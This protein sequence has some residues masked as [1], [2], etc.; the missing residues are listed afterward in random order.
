M[1]PRL[2][3]SL[4]AL[5]ALVAGVGP[6]VA[7]TADGPATQQATPTSTDPVVENTTFYLQLRENGD[8]RWTITD[9]YALE[10]ENDT[11]AF[12]ELAADFRNGDADTGW[13]RAFRGASDAASEATD[14][15]MNVSTVNRSAIVGERKGTLVLTFTW[16]NFAT[17]EGETLVVEDAFNT[18]DGT[19]LKTLA[20]DQRLVIAPPPGY[21]VQSAPAPVQN[22]RLEFAG[23]REFEPGD[24]SVVYTGDT[25]QTPTDTV[26]ETP[27]PDGENVSLWIGGALLIAGLLAVVGYVVTSDDPQQSG[28][29]TAAETPDDAGS[30]QPSTAPDD[31]DTDEIDPELLSDEERVERLLEQNGGR[32]KQARIVQE[33]GWSNAK[34]SQLLSSM[35][36]EDRIDK[37]RIGRENLISFPDEE[38]GDFDDE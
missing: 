23:P 24:V 10:D 1:P 14:R 6:V 9:T 3:A 32:M 7:A 31:G 12:E 4:L 11:E 25:G 5:L 13:L 29:A 15:E 17:A 26:T 28:G 18:S 2:A 21:G 38:I 36:E 27:D 19:W 35:D 20:A 16:T 33:T 30:D 34:V 8:A 22:G 37:L